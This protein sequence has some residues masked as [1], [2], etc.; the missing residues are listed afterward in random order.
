MNTNKTYV[1]YDAT[2]VL[3]HENSNLR[4]FKQ[5]NEWQRIHP[6]RFRF[7]NIDEIYFSSEHD[8]LI[9]STLKTHLLSIMA[10]ADN[11]LVII[12]P[13]TNVES[14][15]LNWQIS[16][17]VNRFH[18]PVIIAYVSKEQLSDHSVEDNWHR[19]PNKIRKYIG[20][21]SARMCHIPLTQDKL[22]RALSTFS[23]GAGT[24]PWNS[25]TIF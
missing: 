22:E 5:L 15:I 13:F 17:A 7:V 19:L 25:T 1:A 23:V 21:D 14:P 18:L 16:R 3:D 20:R 11:L 9:D 12:S 6:E 24:Y 4:T 2:G 10:Q 8:D